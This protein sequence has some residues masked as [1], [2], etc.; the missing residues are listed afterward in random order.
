MTSRL[1]DIDGGD[2]FNRCAASAF[3]WD[4]MKDWQRIARDESAPEDVRVEAAA[5]AR[6]VRAEGGLPKGVGS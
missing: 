1:P 2:L 3:L 4:A 6:A 5:Y